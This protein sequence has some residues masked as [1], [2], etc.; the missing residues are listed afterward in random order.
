MVFMRRFIVVGLFVFVLLSTTSIFDVQ[1]ISGGGVTVII[2]W[3]RFYING[4]ENPVVRLHD[5]IIYPCDGGKPIG[6]YN[7]PHPDDVW[8]NMGFKIA[9]VEYTWHYGNGGGPDSAG[10]AYGT[11]R[12]KEIIPNVL[13]Y[14]SQSGFF[15]TEDGGV[16][17]TC[18]IVSDLPAS[19]DRLSALCG[20]TPDDLKL[21]CNGPVKQ[22]NKNDWLGYWQCD[23]N[24][25]IWGEARLPLFDS[26]GGTGV[27]SLYRVYRRHLINSG[28]SLN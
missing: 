17:N 7:F 25:R 10:I 18:T 3:T 27:G 1:A 28:Q 13:L 20:S 23:P 24:L 4:T 9:R 12:G 8:I 26:E 16:V 2:D 15:R 21:E 19:V 6:F 14:S 22:L 11:C 5:A